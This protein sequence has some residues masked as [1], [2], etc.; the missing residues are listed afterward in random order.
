MS[1]GR[2]VLPLLQRV[3]SMGI[4]ID[5]LLAFSLVNKKAQTCNLSNPAA[6]YRVIED[7]EN[8]NRRGIL[9]KGPQIL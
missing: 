7:I 8:Y 1:E 2:Q 4:D 9:K 3:R 6:A 5:K